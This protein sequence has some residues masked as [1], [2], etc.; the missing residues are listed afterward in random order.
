M[1]NKP[2][3]SATIKKVTLQSATGNPFDVTFNT[4]IAKYQ[5]DPLYVQATVTGST[6]A[7]QILDAKPP[8]NTPQPSGTA[9][10]A[11]VSV[12]YNGTLSDTV[13]AAFAYSG[14]ALSIGMTIDASLSTATVTIIESAFSGLKPAHSHA[15]K[16]EHGPRT[17]TRTEAP[18]GFI[19]IQHDSN[20][21]VYDLYWVTDIPSVKNPNRFTQATIVDAPDVFAGGLSGPM[22]TLIP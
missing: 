18:F 11:A 12:S 22:G 1:P 13:T 8:P 9:T 3:L 19:I 15:A 14:G 6:L 20:S 4:P 17:G 5:G 21:A 10:S 16:R 2:P 7:I